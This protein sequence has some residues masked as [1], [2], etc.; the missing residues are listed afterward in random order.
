[1]KRGLITISLLFLMTSCLATRRD[2]DVSTEQT[3]AEANASRQVM[4]ERFLEKIDLLSNRIAAIEDKMK[5]SE[6]S[7]QTKINMS[8]SS[9]D[10]LKS[11]IMELNNRID[12][13]DVGSKNSVAGF[14]QSIDSLQSELALI[15]EELGL[16]RKKLAKPK[17]VKDVTMMPDGSFALPED[18]EKAYRQLRALTKE[19]K[20]GKEVREAWTSYR[21][22]FSGKRSCDVV[23][24][25]AESYYLEKS[26]NRAIEEFRRIDKEF[27]GCKKREASYLR[28]A[29]SLYYLGKKDVAK[30]L[31]KGIRA[32]FPKSSF[33]KKLKEL[34]K[35]LGIKEPQRRPQRN[36][37]RRSQ[38]QEKK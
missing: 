24:W 9:L 23:Y 1:M 37:Q 30:K 10:E 33:E 14:K 7:Q 5:A 29:Y 35:R 25:N 17:N 12:N 21:N 34:E 36:P 20:Y 32:E 6:K 11:T 19:G 3:R 26:Y 31:L 27:K 8:F 18:S 38:G 28:I 22:K 2:L 16:M 13:V 15:K 4:E